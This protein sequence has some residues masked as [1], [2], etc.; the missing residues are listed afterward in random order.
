MS[1]QGKLDDLEFDNNEDLDIDPDDKS[2]EEEQDD[3]EFEQMKEY[4]EE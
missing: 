1:V 3:L 4:I 2:H